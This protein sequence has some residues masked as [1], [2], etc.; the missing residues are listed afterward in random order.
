MQ[1]PCGDLVPHEFMLEQGMAESARAPPFSFQQQVECHLPSRTEPSPACAAR[2][3]N[4]ATAC[5]FDT[6]IA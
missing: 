4:S 1:L 2:S 6:M 5:G 3:I